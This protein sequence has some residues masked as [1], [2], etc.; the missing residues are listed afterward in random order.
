MTVKTKKF[1]KKFNG[2]AVY[3]KRRKKLSL[4]DIKIICKGSKLAKGI[5]PEK[6]VH[7][8]LSTQSQL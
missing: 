1:I 4:K 7:D 6:L 3:H 5:T 2:A 8:A